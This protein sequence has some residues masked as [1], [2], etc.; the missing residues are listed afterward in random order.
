MRS[1]FLLVLVVSLVLSAY[2]ADQATSN[3]DAAGRSDRPQP[4]IVIDAVHANDFSLLGLQPHVYSYHQS[5]GYRRG[6]EYLQSRGFHRDFFVEGRLTA[7]RLSGRK[8]LFINLVSAERPP[9][10]VSEIAAIC[11]FVADGG[12][13]LVITDH[14]NCY[15]HAYRLQPLFV[16][17]GLE[18]FTATACEEPPLV[19]GE[20]NGW[21]AVRRFQ[22]H[23]VTMGLRCIVPQTGGCVDPRYAVALTS[24]RAWADE[25]L[26]RMYGEDCLPGFYGNFYRD[27]DERAGPLGVVLAKELGKGRIVVVADQNI[28]GDTFINYADNYRL[29]LNTMAW[30]LRDDSLRLPKRYEQSRRPR[31]LFYEEPARAAF[32][33][34]DAE[35]CYHAM[36]FLNRS[37]WTF[38][39]DRLSD[40]ADLIVFARNDEPLGPEGPAALAS[41][42]RRG[43]N[44]LILRADQESL[45]G[46]KGVV[47]QVLAA[48]GQSATPRHTK[49]GTLFQLGSGGEIR[50]LPEDLPVQNERMAPPSEPPKDEEKPRERR[51][52]EIMRQLLA[53]PS[54]PANE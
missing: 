25:W 35:G 1:A 36:S 21:I 23:P 9:L 11:E 37:Y 3:G 30:L 48:L 43:K 32:G 22:E 7:Q 31:V 18:T 24:E 40:G 50:V 2:G 6:F 16:E 12:S 33:L 28:F 8:L 46:P 41:H 52:L 14:S 17:L 45:D 38:A 47:R 29:W 49:D 4:A 27:P 13:L 10:L 42:L 34:T 44:L 51:L 5:A 20:G 15:Y 26:I 54:G 53:K 39:N 19:L